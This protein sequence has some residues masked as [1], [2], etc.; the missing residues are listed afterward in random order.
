V[1]TDK[2]IK[3]RQTRKITEREKRK[4]KDESRGRKEET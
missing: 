1:K 2:V 3:D 4:K